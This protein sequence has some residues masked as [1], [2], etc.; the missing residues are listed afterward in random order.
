VIGYVAT[1]YIGIL[2][3]GL[4]VAF[5]FA[6][7]MSLRWSRSGGWVEMERPTESTSAREES[8]AEAA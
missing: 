5:V 2:F 1:L 3:A 4:A 8:P 7:V 6:A